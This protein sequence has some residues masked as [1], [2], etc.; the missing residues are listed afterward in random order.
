MH[1]FAN[2][3]T[4]RVIPGG[5]YRLALNAGEMLG[6]VRVRPLA[7]LVEMGAD[8]RRRR[9]INQSIA[10]PT[11]MNQSPCSWTIRRQASTDML[12]PKAKKNNSRFFW[13]NQHKAGTFAVIRL[14]FALEK[15]Q[16]FFAA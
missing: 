14:F 13:L 15:K 2:K 16:L 1:F 5:A 11:W 10:H 6:G 12:N 7:T 4:G 8:A 9:R 3:D